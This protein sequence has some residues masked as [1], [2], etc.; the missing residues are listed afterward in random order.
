MGSWMP[1][2]FIEQA[3]PLRSHGHDEPGAGAQSIHWPGRSVVG[4]LCADIAADLSLPAGSTAGFTSSWPCALM[5]IVGS[6]LTPM[7]R[8]R[9]SS[10]P[11]ASL[12]SR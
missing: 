3:G 6:L 12:P 1:I 2:T 5:R 9:T 8:A 7:K 10:R 11:T 4:R